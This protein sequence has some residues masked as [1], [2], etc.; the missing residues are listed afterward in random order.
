VVDWD[1]DGLGDDVLERECGSVRVGVN[2]RVS[3]GV[4]EGVI[5]T[6]RLVVSD[7]DSDADGDRVIVADE[8]DDTDTLTE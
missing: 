5:V 4:L 6:V 1:R 7:L 8:E 3:V 2:V